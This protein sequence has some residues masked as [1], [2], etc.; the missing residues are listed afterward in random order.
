VLLAVSAC[1]FGTAQG[2]H[3][4]ADR[5]RLARIEQW[6]AAMMGTLAHDVRAPLTTV[7]LALETL[8]G[9][10][11]S[12]NRWMFDSALRQT[13]R[14]SRLADSLLDMHR[15]DH[16][17]HLR[18][19]RQLVPARKLVEDALTYI[20][21]TEVTTETDDQLM[22]WVDPARFEQIIINLVG[23]ALKY[24]RPPIVVRVSTGGDTDRLEVRDHGPGIPEA[25]RSTLFSQFTTGEDEGVGLG[26]WIVRQL[27]EAHGGRAFAEAR[28]PGVAMIVTF[29]APGNEG[30]PAGE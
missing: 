29:R 28:T 13:A 5:E 11:T 4:R 23:N 19:D 9:Q 26:L 14:L 21:S 3:L 6:R 10:A 24:G 30:T 27:A 8:R 12:S 7:H 18:L 20:R 22:V 17:G 16:H 1:D 25:I 2:R 15:I